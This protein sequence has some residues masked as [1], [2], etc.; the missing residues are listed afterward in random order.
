MSFINSSTQHLKPSAT[1]LINQ[2]INKLRAV[3]APIQYAAIEA[4]KFKKEVK[5]SVDDSKTILHTLGNYVHQTL[6]QA[7]IN[8]TSPQGGFYILVDF[9][10]YKD[11]LSKL[12]LKDSVSLADHLLEHYGV[13]LLPG[14][15]FYFSPNEFI[16]RLA[17]VDFNGK[18]ALDEYQK[19]KNIPLDLKFIKTFA[20]NIFNGVQIIIDFVN[21]LK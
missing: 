3:S 12:D 5:N 9:N 13:V 4:F 8:C 1:L 21:S 14:V 7:N 10:F 15:D 20:P 18:T 6:T 11:Q 16:F 2:K 19:N 17:Y